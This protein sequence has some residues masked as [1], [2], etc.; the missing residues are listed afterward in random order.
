MNPGRKKSKKKSHWE[1]A[2]DEEGQKVFA[3]WD[4]VSPETLKCE[5]GLL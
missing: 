3:T 1:C 2:P 4:Y 5:L